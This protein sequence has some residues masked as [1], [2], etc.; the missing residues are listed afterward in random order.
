MNSLLSDFNKLFTPALRD[1]F[2]LKRQE[3]TKYPP[4]VREVGD[5][6]ASLTLS[7]GKRIR[8]ALLY[9]SYQGFSQKKK[10]TG[11]VRI[12][13]Y[14]LAIE[15]LHT[16]AL[17]HDDI[18]DQSILR[19]GKATTYKYFQN[20][21]NPRLGLN[22]SILAGDLALSWADEL[23][24]SASPSRSP[25]LSGRQ[26]FG[27]LEGVTKL[28]SQMK[29]E[30]ITGQIMDIFT[31]KTAKEA[32]QMM[33]LKTAQYSVEKPLL[34]GAL[35]AGAN[36][37]ELHTL[38]NLGLKIGIAYQLQDDLLGVF[39]V[40]KTLGKD[41]TSDMKE[42]KMNLLIIK[43]LSQ[44]QSIDRKKFLSLW[45]SPKAGLDDLKEVQKI[46]KLSSGL[47]S[48]NKYY[49]S[50]TKD[51]NANLKNKN[52]TNILQKSLEELI[53]FNIIRQT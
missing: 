10:H 48:F 33:E 18:M 8:P 26:A 2:S 43:T 25:R 29:N 11:S 41:I 31:V 16:W 36:D 46:I 39:G 1:F 51:I 12:Q 5:Q 34:I 42:G 9:Y 40:P 15:I 17:I 14:C 50:L 53:N 4:I 52:I 27:H 47:N 44:L 6:I 19:R 20:K 37:S 24:Y 3:L 22:L 35:L 38:S 7:G 13:N 23:F 28:F 45:G 49:N 32:L 30:V 21:Y